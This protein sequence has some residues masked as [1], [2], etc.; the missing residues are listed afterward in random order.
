MLVKI[1]LAGLSKKA[2]RANIT[3]VEQFLS[4]LD[5]Y[6]NK[7]GKR[8]SKLKENHFKGKG[9]IDLSLDGN[10]DKVREMIYEKRLLKNDAC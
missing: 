5:S 7:I 4:W 2:K 9:F 6:A 1:D 3:I 8:T 10:W